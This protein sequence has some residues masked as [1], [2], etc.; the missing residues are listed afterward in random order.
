MVE[1]LRSERIEHGMTVSGW[2]AKMTS[3]FTVSHI[4]DPK[5]KNSSGKHQR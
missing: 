1:K 3:R 2:A 4:D 5:D